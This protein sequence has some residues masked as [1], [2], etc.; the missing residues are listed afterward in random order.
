MA[1]RPRLCVPWSEW[2]GVVGVPIR[3]LGFVCVRERERHSEAVGA[4]S[5]PRAGGMTWSRLALVL[6]TPILVLSGLGCGKK[7]FFFKTSLTF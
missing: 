3:K 6:L 2:N 1:W 4:R 5:R 7:L